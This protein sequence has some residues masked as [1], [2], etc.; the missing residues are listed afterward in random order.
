MGADVKKGVE[1]AWKDA[2]SKD[3]SASDL[4]GFIALLN[5]KSAN[6]LDFS[7][8]PWVNETVL[9]SLTSWFSHD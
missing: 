6:I 3:K 5:R 8:G 2:K 7:M 9:I 4:P 1:A